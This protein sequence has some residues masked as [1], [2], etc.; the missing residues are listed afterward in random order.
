M[1][2][3]LCETVGAKP[4]FIRGKQQM[5]YM[6]LNIEKI[7]SFR[8]TLPVHFIGMDGDQAIQ[9][10]V[11]YGDSLKKKGRVTFNVW[12]SF[13]G[14]RMRGFLMSADV[15]SGDD[16]I[17]KIMNYLQESDKFMEMAQAFVI[18]FSK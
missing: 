16:L 14:S 4:D 10:T 13:P 8:F 2:F 7:D 1:G 15:K 5:H 9:V 12:C 3:F 6:E 11:E 17:D 18:H